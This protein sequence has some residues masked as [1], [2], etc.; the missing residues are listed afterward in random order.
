MP[1]TYAHYRMGREVADHLHGTERSLVVRYPDLFNIGLHGPD[2]LCYYGALS[3][4][5]VNATGFGLHEKSGAFYFKNAKLVILKSH[6]PEAAQAY[7]YGVLCHFALDVTCHP[8]VAE[9]IQSSGISH[10]EIEVEFDRML[11]LQ[12]GLDPVSHVLTDHIHPQS[13]WDTV[14][15]P[16]YPGVTPRQ[17]GKSLHNMISLNKLL[18]AKN[19][20]KRKIIYGILR[21]TGNYQEM[22]GLIVNPEGNPLCQD[23]NDKLYALYYQAEHLA[24]KLIYSFEDFLTGKTDLDSI[25]DYNF[26]GQLPK[27]KSL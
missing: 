18:L 15:A 11:M 10:A 1:S 22:H 5:P 14:I 9:K 2:I 26:E 8:Y 19:P 24:E 21:L 6:A 16:F 25:F 12:D 27:E 17:V 7:T 20:I 4:N 13:Q 23:S 3:S